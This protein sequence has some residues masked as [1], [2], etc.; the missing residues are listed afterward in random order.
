MEL[1]KE[2][3]NIAGRG[4][5][6]RIVKPGRTGVIVETLDGQKKR[7]MISANARVSVLS[8]ISIYTED[9]NKSVPLADIFV[10]IREKNGEKVELDTKNASTSELFDFLGSVMPDFDR[11]RVHPS[12]VKKLVQWYNLLSTQMPE[13]WETKTEEIVEEKEGE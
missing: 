11:E 6:F 3:A 12:D 1:L 5:L 10:A 8:D 9:F 2:V 13:L 7:E 4:G